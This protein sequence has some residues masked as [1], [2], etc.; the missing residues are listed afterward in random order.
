MPYV[1]KAGIKTIQNQIEQWRGV[2]HDP[3]LDGFTG[4]GCKQKIYQVMWEAQKALENSPSY[5]GEKE[6]VE[7]NGIF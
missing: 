2:M 3:R 4:W 6:W 7:Q 5:V 1:E